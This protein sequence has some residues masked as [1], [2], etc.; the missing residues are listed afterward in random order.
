[1][2]D[3]AEMEL[4]ARITRYG[5]VSEALAALDERELARLVRGAR[6]LAHGIGG[7][8][9]LLT[10]GDTPVFVKRIPLSDRERRPEHVLST[11]N[12][13]GLP[14]Y[15]QYGVG[16]PGFGVWREV[17]ANTMTTDWVLARR[18]EAFPLLY[19]WRTL[20]GSP[21]LAEELA[22]VDRTVAYLHGSAAVRERIEAAATA[23]A[24]VVLFLEY[25]PDG[26]DDWLRSRLAE[27]PAAIATAAAMVERRLRLD[28]G[29]LNSAGLLH[30]DAHFGNIRT[31]GTRL[32]LVDLGLASSPRFA[33]SAAEADFVA[34]HGSHD[35]GYA[36][37]QLLNWLVVHVCG[38]PVPPAGGPVQR[39]DYLRRCAAGGEIAGAP[40]AIAALIRR[41]A[42]VAVAVND[43]YWELFG[44]SRT[45]P[46]PAGRIDP[47]VTGLPP[48]PAP[49]P[50]AAP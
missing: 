36:L 46:Y 25:V 8:S 17:T 1:M 50:A 49:R 40:P 5:R 16:G 27:G 22:D 29:F 21:P 45:T 41:Y 19:H 35:V 47:L 31:D 15:C 14:P 38:V 6:P 30:F 11:A 44:T 32:Y 26:L 34:R 3:S 4:P 43:F 23:S 24:S 39:N 42:P 12:L 37:T 20:P 18:T 2:T 48:L 33:L 7:T 13:F 10:I 9:A 28:L